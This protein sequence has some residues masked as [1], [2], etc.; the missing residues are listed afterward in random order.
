MGIGG[1]T[2]N[3]S[4]T[5]AVYLSQFG[6]APVDGLLGLSRPLRDQQVRTMHPQLIRLSLTNP[7]RQNFVV[8]AFAQNATKDQVFGIKLASNGSELYIGGTNEDLYS[9]PFEYH[10]V[11]HLKDFDTY[12]QIGNAS[13]YVDNRT[14]ASNVETIIDSGTTLVLGPEDEVQLLYDSVADSKFNIAMGLYTFPCN[15]THSVAF[16]WGGRRWTIDKEL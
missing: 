8:T 3:L 7:L 4:F 1:V 16:S 10:N 9:G 13:V 2:A 6:D 11:T 5:S 12:W 14:V 15:H